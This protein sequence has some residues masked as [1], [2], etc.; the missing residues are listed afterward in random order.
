M[1]LSAEDIFDIV[2]SVPS[3]SNETVQDKVAR[4]I[5]TANANGGSDNVTALL[6]AI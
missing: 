3:D 6:I 2:A 5:D 1:L 4:L